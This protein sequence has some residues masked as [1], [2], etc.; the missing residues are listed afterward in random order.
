MRLDPPQPEPAQGRALTPNML[1]IAFLVREA[2]LTHGRAAA[3]A[4]WRMMGL[5]ELPFEPSA[6]LPAREPEGGCDHILPYLR[7]R[8][9]FT[10]KNGDFVRSKT[11]YEAFCEFMDGAPP[12]RLRALSSRLYDLAPVYRCPASGKCSW[13]G[14][15][16]HTG[17]RG[18][19]LII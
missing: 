10:G 8:L 2:R 16:N 12:L 18:L 14:R 6:S 7:E 17:Y 15:S 3:R 9:F 11:I 5:P 13:P 1:D 4:L 19:R